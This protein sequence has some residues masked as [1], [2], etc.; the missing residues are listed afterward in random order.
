[1]IGQ[2]IT[3]GIAT[4][5]ATGPNIRLKCH[6]I[7]SRSAMRKARRHKGNGQNGEKKHLPQYGRGCADHSDHMHQL[8]LADNTFWRDE[9]DLK[10][11][12]QPFD[13]WQAA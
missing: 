10:R 7:H 13:G 3:I 9:I 4:Q 6:I 2:A 1:M 5:I 11:A 8:N 12:R